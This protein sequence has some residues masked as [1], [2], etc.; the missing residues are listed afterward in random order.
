MKQLIQLQFQDIYKVCILKLEG[1]YYWA[2]AEN[3]LSIIFTSKK[4]TI[5]TLKKRNF[6]SLRMDHGKK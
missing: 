1:H 4:D 6:Q 5:G 3:K 2:V